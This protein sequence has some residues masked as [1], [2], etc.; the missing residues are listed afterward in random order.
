[1][2]VAHNDKFLNQ[3]NGDWKWDMSGMK[4]TKEH[5]EKIGNSN[6]GRIISDETRRKLSIANTGKHVGEKNNMYGRKRDDISN[7]NSET[8]AKKYLVS[9]QDSPWEEIT[10]LYQFSKER[11]LNQGTLYNTMYDSKKSHKGWR[12]RKIDQ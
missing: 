6:L 1:M 5:C 8:K 4:F 11:G 9:Y 12:V 10:N 3:R 2:N 7:W